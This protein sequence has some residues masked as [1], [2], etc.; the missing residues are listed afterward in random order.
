MK[1]LFLFA[2]TGIIAAEA[3]SAGHIGF[4]YPA[5]A[6]RGTVTTIVLGGQGIGG[7]REIDAGP[8]ISIEKITYV[9]GFPVPAGDQRRYMTQWIEAI[10][11]G[12][13]QP[14]MPENT[15]FWRVSPWYDNMDKLDAL[16]TAIFH[17]WFFTPRNSLQMSPSINQRVIVKLKIDKDAPTGKRQLRLCNRNDIT[18]QVP[19][20]VSDVPEINEPLYERP[21]KK[22]KT[23]RPFIPVPGVANGQIYPGERD[24]FFFKAR[25]GEIISFKTTARELVPFIGD[26]VPGHFQA[27]LEVF[28]SKGKTVAFADDHHFNPDPLL[29]FKAPAD[30]TYTLIIR[31][32]I[33]RGRADFVYRI[34]A[35]KGVKKFIIPPA[36]QRIR[37][38]LPASGSV[39]TVP[40]PCRMQGVISKPGEK[41]TFSLNASPEKPVV[42]ELFARRM[43]SPL[44]GIIK[45]F[46]QNGKL[47]ASNDDIKRP[48]VGTI[49]HNADSYLMFKAP[50]KGIYKVELTD[51]TGAGSSEH[52]Y[53]L[54][55]DNPRPGFIGYVTPSLISVPRNGCKQFSAVV[56]RLDG[57]DKEITLEVRNSHGYYLTGAK[58]IPANAER[59]TFTLKAPAAAKHPNKMVN[60]S[61]A[62]KNGKEIVNF[63][64]GD[65]LMQAFAYYHIV[66]SHKLYIAPSWAWNAHLFSWSSS[67]PVTIEKGKSYRF[68]IKFKDLPKNGNPTIDSVEPIDPP[69]GV[70]VSDMKVQN[71]VVSFNYN[72]SKECTPFERNQL[73]LLRA[74]YDGAPNRSGIIRRN[75][76]VITMPVRRISVK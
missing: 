23:P 43:G 52:Y 19:F 41:M 70:T 54:R 28:D 38:L 27:V 29:I 30:D 3:F 50:Q 75:K 9:P 18:N 5:G 12:T 45:V 14:K 74:S 13:P 59:A 66:P 25:K 68:E 72:V 16:E 7:K 56:E 67:A 4:C 40:V 37:N 48:R 33:Y 44:D 17:R 32:S 57:Y 6:K 31:D 60:I 49:L 47:V 10:E 1:K 21:G 62:A 11:K 35:S 42:L 34:Q 61:I 15:Q 65:E 46:D 63:T 24:I 36:P 20:F 2:V 73:F 53:H 39:G 71:N 51:T 22:V 8:G 64:A 76:N 55:I 58:T 26:G 69:R